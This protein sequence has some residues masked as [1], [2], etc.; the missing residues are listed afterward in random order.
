MIRITVGKAKMA[1]TFKNM[2]SNN[3]DIELMIRGD[4]IDKSAK[5]TIGDGGQV[6]AQISRKIFNARELIGGQQTYYVTVAP[7]VDVAM[8]AAFCVCLDEAEN[9]KK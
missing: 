6:I 8:V 2:A 1:V 9:E 7:G 4:W 3:A 5:I